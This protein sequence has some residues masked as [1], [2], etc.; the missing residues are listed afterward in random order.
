MSDWFHGLPCA[1]QKAFANG[2]IFLKNFMTELSHRAAEFLHRV[3]GLLLTGLVMSVN[4]A[5]NIIGQMILQIVSQIISAGIVGFILFKYRDRLKEFIGSVVQSA[6]SMVPEHWV[7]EEAIIDLVEEAAGID[8]PS[9]SEVEAEEGE[10]KAGDSKRTGQSTKI[11]REST[12]LLTDDK[13]KTTK[14][15]KRVQIKRKVPA[16]EMGA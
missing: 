7:D 10:G 12:P 9:D 16:K 6:G 13:S 8:T 15:V 5:R 4:T 11:V 14:V 1:A 2:M 3:P